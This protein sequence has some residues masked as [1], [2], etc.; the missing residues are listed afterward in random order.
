MKMICIREKKEVYKVK[1][2]SFSFQGL[3]VS[4]VH[5]LQDT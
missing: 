3:S 4:S 1:N 5:I 2:G